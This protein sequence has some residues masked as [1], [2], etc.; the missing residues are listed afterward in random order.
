LDN[1]FAKINESALCP[2]CGKEG[3]IYR[4]RSKNVIERSVKFWSSYRMYRCSDC[5]WRGMKLGA[6]SN[7]K[8]KIRPVIIFILM[9]IFTYFAGQ[10]L[11]EYLL[12]K[13]VVIP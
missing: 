4:S 11:S 6:E 10:L 5:G 1:K 7:P 3:T 12:S 2:K 8:F 9:L 13:N